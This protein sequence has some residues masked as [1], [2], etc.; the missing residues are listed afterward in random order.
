MGARP[1]RAAGRRRG[2][3]V[4]PVARRGPGRPGG[5]GVVK[6][7]AIRG[8]NLAS[9]A[10]EFEIDLA[11]GPLGEAG[12]FAIVGN[13]GS[14]KSTL[15]D[16]LC[17][18][19]FDRTPRLTNHSTVKVGR[20][21]DERAL[22]GAQDVRTLLRR[23]AAQGWAEV[24]FES[25]DARQY[26]AR[27]S[28]RRAR[29][30]SDGTLQDEQLSLTAITGGE[31]LGGTK[32]ETLRAIH[33]R[34][35]LSFDQFRRSALL[36]Q[37]E[38]AAFLRAD[39]KDRSELLERMTGTQIYSQL[40]IAAH[41]KAAL[42][43]QRL[44]EG[45]AAALA[46]SVLDEVAERALGADLE[47]AMVAAQVA[48]QRHAEA[49]QLARW[50]AEAARRGHAL[51]GAS[52]EHAAARA[53]MVAAEP[54]RAE[55]AL[56]QR[57]ERLRPAWDEVDRLERRIAVAVGE[58]TA[59]GEA[60]AEAT[61]RLDGIAERRARIA[62][63]HGPVRAAR[64]AAGIVE[65][66]GF[67]PA[68]GAVAAIAATAADDAAWL[69]ACA[70]LAPEVAAWP[71]L[72]GRF[73]QHEALCEA[74]A[75][76]D[77][78]LAEHTDARA[79][80]DRTRKQAAD[81]VQ[82]ATRKHDEA[83]RKAQGFAQKRGTTLDAA[84]RLEDEAR[85]RLGE[86]ERLVAIA[87]E[88]RGAVA[89]RDEIEHQVAELAV[90][91][92]GDAAQR[93]RLEG[94]QHSAQ[95]VRGE[96]VRLVDE[97]RRAAGYEHARA[98]LA[99][100]EPCPLCGATEHPWRNRGALD[101]VIAAADDRLAGTVAALD[102][103]AAEL[104][105]ITARDRQR[106]RDRARLGQLR[107]A[108]VASAGGAVT[109]WR[110]RLGALGE[111]LLVDDP[112]LPA[113]EALAADRLALARDKLEAARA[114]R[115]QTEAASK[116]AHDAQAE[117][118]LCQVALDQVASKLGEID[119]QRAERDATIGRV[120][121]EHA[122]KLEQRAALTR[123]LVAAM[124]RWLAALPGQTAGDRATAVPA[125]T[126]GRS[127]NARRPE[128]APAAHAGD[129][130]VD[131]ALAMALVA[132]LQAIAPARRAPGAPGSPLAI[133]RIAIA[134]VVHGWRERAGRIAEAD[135]ALTAAAAEVE[136]EVRDIER[137]VAEHTAR[138]GD[139]E[140]RRDELGRELA[141]AAARLD[142]RRGDAGFGRDELRRLLSSD[143]SRVDALAERLAALER[144]V[145]RTRAVVTERER[146]VAEHAA[147]AQLAA[148]AEA[149]D[150]RAA[151][152]ADVAAAE[153]AAEVDRIL[154]DVIGSHDGKLFRSFAQ[155][156]TL[157]SLLAVANAHLEELAPRYQLERVPR[158][159]LE[160]QVI[161]RD[162]G[163]EVRSVQSLSGGESFLVSLALALGLSSMSAH[164]VRVR[165]LLI[166][167]GFGTLDPATLDSA[168]S[169]LD[170]L[171]ATGRQVGVISH[172]P[173]LVERVG[174]HVRVVQRGGGRSEVIVA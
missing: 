171:Q 139:A 25:G 21:S 127:G 75:G 35:G 105:A 66:T 43:E 69:A 81:D 95:A 138:R 97:L 85:T 26:R 63:A 116:A 83:K 163:A 174:A 68:A 67:G 84:R 173:A 16:A 73:A 8:C 32:T 102:G 7:L 64:I 71:E 44:R 4:R 143:P 161:D 30:Q 70:A 20:G 49:E 47:A 72:D 146:A 29:G 120:R 113:A 14:G 157:D 118:Q 34:L 119:R 149:R 53:A 94:A 136:R 10:G 5:P 117:V 36:A 170:A 167:E 123:E 115:S 164:D 27:W 15:L 86:I 76:L 92:A 166:D 39:G 124:A 74:I 88:A 130:E 6:I 50:S 80:L 59:A 111:L 38:F 82:A 132:R 52:T 60:A 42:A 46:I 108:A 61:R 54:D 77:R 37:G 142:A 152:L 165:T 79:R 99:D 40:S 131:P 135:A 11:R 3:R 57:A 147:A 153:T 156:L 145:E 126:R 107:A 41:V 128:D 137:A 33:A 100:G 140:V 56:R 1:C 12:V 98:E 160:L 121:G 103:I 168:L 104:A 51:A 114:T 28:V 91:A 155:S 18:A 141:A 78:A 17:V 148:N 87:A 150:R 89:T 129:G 125:A 93:I 31:R 110:D 134:G 96:Q 169:V 58:L 22:L 48:R 158:H 122:S 45:R 151:A 55:L 90:A 19:L 13:T 162:L 24:D 109:A 133:V 9:L 106:D 112:A 154:G 172:V 159:D 144:A 101:G 2:R 23:G 65:R 62:A